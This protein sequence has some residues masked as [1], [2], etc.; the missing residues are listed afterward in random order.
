MKKVIILTNKK[1]FH[2]NGVILVKYLMGR[3][4]WVDYFMIQQTVIYI[5]SQNQFLSLIVKK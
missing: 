2:I 1:T 3:K 5:A 4:S